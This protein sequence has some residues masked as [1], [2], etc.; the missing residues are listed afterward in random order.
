MNRI[1][2]TAE[3]FAYLAKMPDEWTL[4][5]EGWKP[6]EIFLALERVG[7]AD[8]KSPRLRTFIC[9]TPNGRRAVGLGPTA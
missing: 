2:L 8:R 4:Q 9:R 1:E 5:P 7:L 6:D 3:T